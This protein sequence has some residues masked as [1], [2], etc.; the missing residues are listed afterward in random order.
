MRSVLW[1]VTPKHN[2]PPPPS[3]SLIRSLAGYGGYGGV[4]EITDRSQL[5]AYQ[6]IVT[7][8]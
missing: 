2:T 1:R 6:R 4:S 8:K 7:T 3:H 5:Q